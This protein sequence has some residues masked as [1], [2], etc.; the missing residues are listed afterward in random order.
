MAPG[1]PGAS[2]PEPATA[3][4]EAA[5]EL[6]RTRADTGRMRRCFVAVTAALLLTIC[7]KPAPPPPTAI[8]GAIAALDHG[9]RT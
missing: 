7:P 1:V 2:A 4:R 5:L 9:C 8:L 3:P 6:S